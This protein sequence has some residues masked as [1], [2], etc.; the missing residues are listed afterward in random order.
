MVTR[1][2][3]KMSKIKFEVLR[4]VAELARLAEHWSAQGREDLART[5]RLRA[6][7]LGAEA[8]EMN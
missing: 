3:V 5:Y 1:W 2:R 7:T 8:D 6:E 4:Q